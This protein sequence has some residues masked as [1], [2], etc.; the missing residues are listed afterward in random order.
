MTK[1]NHGNYNPL[2]YYLTIKESS[3]DGLGL[4]ATEDIP[5]YTNAGISHVIPSTDLMKILGI[6]VTITKFPHYLIRTPIGGFLNHG[7]DANV[8]LAK[9]PAHYDLITIKEIKKG[10]EL[11]I[12]YCTAPCGSVEELN[13]QCKK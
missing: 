6:G 12:D 7:E 10:E 11:L 3:I 8:V 2:P 5:K 1:L 9:S 4:F 13:I